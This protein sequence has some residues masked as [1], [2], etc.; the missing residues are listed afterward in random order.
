M[1]SSATSTGAGRDGLRGPDATTAP[2][3]PRRTAPRALGEL[4]GEFG[5]A[6]PGHD[7]SPAP[8]GAGS[9]PGAGPGVG[10]PAAIS[11]GGGH[12]RRSGAVPHRLPVPFLPRELRL[13]RQSP[14][15]LGIDSGEPV[16]GLRP[17][18][19]QWHVSHSQA[20]TGEGEAGLARSSGRRGRGP[21]SRRSDHQ[22]RRSTPAWAA[23][24]QSLD[25][26]GGRTRIARAGH[27]EAALSPAW[28]RSRARYHGA[29]GIRSTKSSPPGRLD[30]DPSVTT[31]GQVAEFLTEQ[32]G[33]EFALH[34]HHR[35]AGLDRSR[36][37]EDRRGGR[38][39]LR[40][41]SASL[42]SG[43]R[44]FTSARRS[45]SNHGMTT[46][47]AWKQRSPSRVGIATRSTTPRRAARIVSSDSPRPFR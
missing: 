26:P 35:A 47:R 27:P 45:P 4:S 31:G 22:R 14:C 46:P 44:I 9:D 24:V 37:G 12:G 1:K 21:S 10:T 3:H 13:I 43:W 28:S 2:G 18:T 16:P 6:E 40:R 25:S 7:P 23:S 15:P 20:N 19:G 32:E 41:T 42:P 30:A 11:V 29:A 38:G 33:V 17:G 39:R 5:A 36:A 34:D 8:G